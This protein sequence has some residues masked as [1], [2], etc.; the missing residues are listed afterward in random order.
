MRS[1]W[2]SLLI[3]P[4]LA[5]LT[6]ASG[7][8]KKDT[9]PDEDRP[10]SRGGFKSRGDTGSATVTREPLKAPLDGVIRGKVTF[11]GEKPKMP[12]IEAMKV[13]ESSAVCLAGKPFEKVEQKWLIGDDG[14][15]ANVLVFLKAPAG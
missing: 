15:V 1:A 8:G 3:I 13:H 10:S 14:G 2:F 4:A 7:C 12:E 9:E 11:V 5:M 6:A